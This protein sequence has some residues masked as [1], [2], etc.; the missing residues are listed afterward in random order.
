MYIL[1]LTGGLASGKST[2]SRMFAKAGIPVIDADAIVH[3]L[4]A[5]YTDV[6]MRLA[7]ELGM[8]V[9]NADGGVDR[10]ILSQKIQADPGLLV[11]LENIIH[12]AVRAEERN[13][14]Q[15]A[16]DNGATLAV[17]D[18]PLLFES[19]GNALCDSVA[20]CLCPMGLRLKRA[21]E[22]PGMTEAK[23]LTLQA[24]RIP[25]DEA[26]PL[27]QHHILT[28]TDIGSTRHQVHELI[29][30]LKKQPAQA[31]PARWS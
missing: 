7:A 14:L 23:F 10:R 20:W 12:P 1:G 31:W 18:V 9:L 28:D 19:G 15:Q 6:S 2:V 8:D 3:Q 11:I 4:Q 5:P 16:A 13:Q 29:E 22:R 25:D 17:L 26:A 24:R 30:A 21:L 27:A